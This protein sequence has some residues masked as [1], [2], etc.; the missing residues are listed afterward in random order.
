MDLGHIWQQVIASLEATHPVLFFAAMALLPLGPFPASILFISAGVRFGVGPG[1]CLGMAA[2]AINMTL[3]YFLAHR[4]VRHPL[5]RWIRKR[6]YAVPEFGSGDELRFL[7]LFR[8]T[9]G[10]PLFVQNYV[11]GV[12]GMRFGLYLPVSLLVQVPFVL[13]F[14]WIGQSLTQ[15]SAWR[16][17]AAVAAVVSAVLLVSLVRRRMSRRRQVP[18]GRG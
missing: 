14:V 10:M 13:G 16:I 5:E 6:G 4:V 1:F 18:P 8:I 7:L 11:L 15:T 2:L 12:S 9:P 3:G 17:A